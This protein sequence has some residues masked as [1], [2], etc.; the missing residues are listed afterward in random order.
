MYSLDY[1][2]RVVEYRLEN[3]TTKET[4]EIFKIGTTTVNKWVKELK[5]TGELKARY[6]S[7]NRT[8]KKID[9]EKF[10]EYLRKNSDAFQKEMALHFNCCRRS[11]TQ[12]MEN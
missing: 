7:S 3:H 12:L 5:V 6:D 9:P 2:K 1:K 10:K 8:F 4:A 11:I